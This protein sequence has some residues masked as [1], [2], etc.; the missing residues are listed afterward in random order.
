MSGWRA[1]AV[2]DQRGR[3]AIV[4]GADSGIGRETARALAAAGARVVLACRDIDRGAATAA[5]IGRAH[6][7]ADLRVA[8]LDL[9]DLASVQRF[10]EDIG[11]REAPPDLLI[12]NAGV[13]ALPERRTADGFEYQIG[14]NHLGHFA[15]TGR[16]L[17]RLAAGGRVVTVSSFKHRGGVVDPGDLDG[18]R[19]AYGPWA[20]YSQSKLANLL[21]AFELQ[22]RL[23]AA[24]RPLVSVAAHPGYAATDLQLAGPRERGA[25]WRLRA[26]R[27]ANALFGQSA[28]RG[29]LPSLYAATAASVR[30]GD[31]IGPDGP[32]ELW[33]HP[34]RVRA[35]P[36][37][38]RVDVARALWAVSLA[39][40]GVHY[41][42]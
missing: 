24:G 27:L 34:V 42:V 25:R 30:G 35:R 5:D 8:G 40:T 23:A 15:L 10:T 21:F 39:R 14:V 12:N 33:G 18:D 17:D 20:A 28:A 29:A 4:T 6:P 38:G 22:C 36:N 16:L 32:R 19:R 11:E 13:M 41:P 2:P 37:A 31:Y 9:A 26:A 1:E 7:A 3:L